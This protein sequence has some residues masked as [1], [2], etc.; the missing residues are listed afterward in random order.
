VDVQKITKMDAFFLFQSETPLFHH[1]RV[2]STLFPGAEKARTVRL[3][4]PK[5]TILPSKNKKGEATN[6]HTHTNTQNKERLRHSKFKFQIQIARNRTRGSERCEKDHTA[7][8]IEHVLA[9]LLVI[10][11][12]NRKR[13]S[14][15]HHLSST[16]R[17]VGS[18]WTQY[19]ATS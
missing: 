10:F 18:C 19:G 17:A 4:S 1:E 3:Q 13:Q 2:S 5:S 9:L 12:E 16:P 7:I 6:T 15:I 14:F 8:I 11:L